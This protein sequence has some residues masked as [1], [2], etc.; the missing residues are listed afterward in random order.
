MATKKL[1]Q[2]I[3]RRELCRLGYT[4]QVDTASR[5]FMVYL[6][7]MPDDSARYRTPDLD[8]ALA[9]G[10]AMARERAPWDGR[11]T[12]PD[13][14]DPHMFRAGSVSLGSGQ[15]CQICGSERNFAVHMHGAAL[16]SRAA[17]VSPADIAANRTPFDG[18]PLLPLDPHEA[19]VRSVRRAHGLPDG[20]P[21]DVIED[22]GRSAYEETYEAVHA[23]VEPDSEPLAYATVL[24]AVA[25]SLNRWRNPDNFA[26]HPRT[27]TAHGRLFNAIRHA[28]QLAIEL[29]RVVKEEEA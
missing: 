8:D 3:V 18:A 9:T 17:D 7:G 2:K 23:L 29:T 13:P 12:P 24:G 11:V 21:A 26:L 19:I 16:P 6:R 4:M 14:T 10:R 5:E 1:T 25:D 28:Q 27:L 22:L 15:K 20:L